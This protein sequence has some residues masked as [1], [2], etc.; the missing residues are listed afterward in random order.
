MKL[1]AEQLKENWNKFIGN[2][3]TYISSPRKEQLLDFYRT[4]EDRFIMMPASGNINF[5]NCFP[6]GYVD[7]I[8]RVVKAA[9]AVRKMW[10]EF[11]IN[12]TT[13]TE[14]ELVFA[15]I[16]H[17]LGKVGNAT[18]D[19]YQPSTDD[20][21]KNKLGEHYTYNSDIDFMLIPD[22]SL[23]LLQEAGIQY[24]VNEM[25]AIRTHDGLYDDSNKAYYISRVPGSRPKSA[26]IFI[27]HQ[28]DM[29]ASEVEKDLIGKTPLVVKK[30]VVNKATPKEKALGNLKSQGVNSAVAKFFN[31]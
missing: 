6:G 12:E 13:F 27:L 21:R 31:T 30:P 28:A 11:G 22:R 19:L 7:H 14:E 25:L 15:A 18:Q 5:H 1:T 8:N 26:I 10:I 16:N 2:I 20:W 24:T 4:Q 9:L 29:M 17:D 23:F 3:D